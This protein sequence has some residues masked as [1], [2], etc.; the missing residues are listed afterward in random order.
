MPPITHVFVTVPQGR[1]VPVPASDAAVAGG[2]IL[3]AEW[4]VDAEG[5]PKTKANLYALPWNTYTRKRVRSGDFVLANSS[6]TTVKEAIEASAPATTKLDETGAVAADQRPDDEINK[7]TAAKVAAD[8]AA[9][10]KRIELE[11]APTRRI[12]TF[13][14]SD[15][16]K[17]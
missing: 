5:N 11:T 13:D 1:K 15:K 7:E 16:G 6:G 3:I 9:Q 4:G 8:A 14:T 12:P 17:E 2:S 10:A